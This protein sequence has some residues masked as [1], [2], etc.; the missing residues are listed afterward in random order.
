MH[1]S[2]DLSVPQMQVLVLVA[3]GMTFDE[4][5]DT[6]CYSHKTL[7]GVMTR[8]VARLSTNIPIM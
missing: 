6:L 3:H 5:A 7:A 8:L 4:I 1:N 2:D